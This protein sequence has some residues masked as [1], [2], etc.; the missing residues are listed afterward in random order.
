MRLHPLPMLH[1]ENALLDC[2]PDAEFQIRLLNSQKHQGKHILIQRCGCLF[3]K[4][5][6]VRFYFLHFFL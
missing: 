3:K 5:I 1:V 6:A 2:R 4:S